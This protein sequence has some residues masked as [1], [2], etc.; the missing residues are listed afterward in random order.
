MSTNK[1]ELASINPEDSRELKELKQ[2]YNDALTLRKIMDRQELAI[3]GLRF[4]AIL[5]DVTGETVYLKQ[6]L[7]ESNLALKAIVEILLMK[8]NTGYEDSF[9]KLAAQIK[10]VKEQIKKDINRGLPKHERV[11]IN[12]SQE[13]KGND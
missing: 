11:Q 13:Y 3:E 9:Y 8:T 5:Y 6:M 7:H 12:I 10:S 1:D 2:K 4:F